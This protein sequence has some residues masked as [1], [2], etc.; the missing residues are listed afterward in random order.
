VPGICFLGRVEWNVAQEC[1]RIAHV[2]KNH[3]IGPV[4]VPI[5]KRKNHRELL[6]TLSGHVMD[7]PANRKNLSAESHFLFAHFFTFLWRGFLGARRPASSHFFRAGPSQKQIH[8][9]TKLP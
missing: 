1:N 2:A 8:T 5:A 6:P 3:A 9:A 7:N 4:L